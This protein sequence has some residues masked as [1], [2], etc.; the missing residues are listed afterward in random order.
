MIVTVGNTKG[1]VGKS[2][3]SVNLAVESSRR[4]NKTLLIDTDPQ[5]ST[6]AFRG[7][8]DSDDINAIALISDK[9]H[10]DIQGF[11]DAF[12]II[13][14]DAGGRDNKVF[15]S[16]VAAC[17][18]FLVPVLPSQFDVWAAEDSLKVFKEIQ[19]FNDMTGHIVMNMVR[20][21]TIVSA[22][23]H[24]ALLEYASDLPLLSETLHNRVAYKTSISQG[25]GVSEYEPK[26]KAATEIQD[27]Y[28]RI[29]EHSKEQA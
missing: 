17:E 20:P 27:L 5:G 15:R 18:K 9:L 24:E 23:A 28:S 21:N 22:E 25:L 12:D 3:I 13:I 8:R 14:I 26:G 29:F 19:P 4:G 6:M 2:T 7:E 10:K 1:G 11:R 16:A